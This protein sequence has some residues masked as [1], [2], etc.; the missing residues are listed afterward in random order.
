MAT[1][2]ISLLRRAPRDFREKTEFLTF[3]G[4]M[5]VFLL[6]MAGVSLPDWTPA[7]IWQR[8]P[9]TYKVTLVF[10]VVIYELTWLSYRMYS[11]VTSQQVTAS[12]ARDRHRKEL[13]GL[14]QNG[15]RILDDWLESGEV[16]SLSSAWQ[17]DVNA[18]FVAHLPEEAYELGKTHKDQHRSQ[19]DPQIRYQLKES[20]VNA[21]LDMLENLRVVIRKL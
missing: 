16:D 9:A 10:L 1:Y 11:D 13:R 6:V 2:L 7:D 19:S 15:Q 8:L 18:Y 5:L 4:P 21:H 3:W 14:L 20:G 12:V 17:R